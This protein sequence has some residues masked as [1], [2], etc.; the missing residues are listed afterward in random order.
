VKYYVV[1][2]LYLDAAFKRMKP[3][4]AEKYGPFDGFDRAR[5]KWHERAMATIDDTYYRFTIVEE[6]EL[7]GQK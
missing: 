3:G 2:G 4:T 5:I 1:G 6:D 7:P